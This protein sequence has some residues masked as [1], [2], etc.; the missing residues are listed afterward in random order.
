MG[1]TKVGPGTVLG[2]Y[3]LG[4]LIGKGGMAQVFAATDR[5][6]GRPVAI[7]VLNFQIS[8]QAEFRARF[9]REAR[10]MAGLSHENIVKVFDCG[11]DDTWAWMAMELVEGETLEQRLAREP[12][13]PLTW[14]VEV[15]RAVLSALDHVHA[16]EIVHRDV[17]PQNVLISKADE[18]KLVD[19]GLVKVEDQL[20]VTRVGIRLGTPRYMSPEAARGEAVT[21]QSD[22]FSAGL[23]LHELITGRLPMEEIRDQASYERLKTGVVPLPSRQRPGLPEDMDKIVVKAL[24]FKSWD[25]FDNAKKFADSLARVRLPSAEPA[26]TAGKPADARSRGDRT[27]IEKVGAGA[28][29]DATVVETFDKAKEDA[30]R[31]A[32]RKDRKH[33][34]HKSKHKKKR[35]WPVMLGVVTGAV[36]ALVVAAVLFVYDRTVVRPKPSPTATAAVPSS[37]GP[38]SPSPSA[39]PSVV[40]GSPLPVGDPRTELARARAVWAE[41]SRPPGMGGTS[42]GLQLGRDGQKHLGNILDA[43]GARSLEEGLGADGRREFLFLLDRFD[44]TIT[45]V[46]D[47]ESLFKGM[48]VEEAVLGRVIDIRQRIAGKNPRLAILDRISVQEARDPAFWELASRCAFRVGLMV[49]AVLARYRWQEAMAQPR[50]AAGGAPLLAGELK[51]LSRADQVMLTIQLPKSAG[52]QPISPARGPWSSVWD[53]IAAVLSGARPAPPTVAPVVP[54]SPSPKG[55]TKDLGEGPDE[56]GDM[57]RMEDEILDKRPVAPKGPV[58]VRAAIRVRQHR[59]A[60][61]ALEA[62]EAA[63]RE[64]TRAP[65]PAAA[66]DGRL[67]KALA[68]LIEQMARLRAC[69]KVDEAAVEFYEPGQRSLY[70]AFGDLHAY[71]ATLPRLEGALRNQLLEYVEALRLFGDLP[72]DD[73]AYWVLYGQATL[74]VGQLGI[75]EESFLRAL[76]SQLGHPEGRGSADVLTGPALLGLARTVFARCELNGDPGSTRPGLLD[77]TLMDLDLFRMHVLEL[78]MRAVSPQVAAGWSWTPADLQFLGACAARVRSILVRRGEIA[79][80]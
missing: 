38:A 45:R 1:V 56:L 68:A 44:E 58:V 62:L 31:E 57:E 65:G 20:N 6:L 16:R 43:L 55:A 36:A 28:D 24:A 34:K 78:G 73:A 8:R 29:R 40:P 26:P 4:E 39:R 7:K 21:Y 67:A 72:V 41:I 70:Q 9:L 66:K 35:R 47:A 60:A 63:I 32:A 2:R 3:E 52:V 17:K 10:V 77:H 23:L 75:A 54:A 71:F 14:V 22:L 80:K 64:L 18:I 50:R 74:M 13:P 37:P 51:L 11:E 27:V 15:M 42:V 61:P 19:F 76:G 46:R 48:L 69:A 53:R 25:R 12:Q 79:A 59:M 49:P 33:R 30:D 5:E